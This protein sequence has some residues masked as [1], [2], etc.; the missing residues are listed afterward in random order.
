VDSSYITIPNTTGRESGTADFLIERKYGRELTDSIISSNETNL[1]YD[2]DLTG[3]P[4]VNVRVVIDE[5]TNDEIR[6]RGN[7]NLRIIAGTTEP[8]T[9]RGRFDI[10]DGIYKFSFQSFFKKPFELNKNANNYIEWNG[11]PNHPTV[12]IEGVYKTKEKVDFSPLL[13]TGTTGDNVTGYRDY[14][15][16]IAK[17]KGDLFKP[18]IKFDLDFPPE[19]PVKKDFYASQLIRVILENE[20][21]LNKHV[22]FLVVFNK[23]APTDVGSSLKTSGV[24][25]VVNSISG[26]LSGQINKWLNNFL[27]T[28]FKIEGLNINFS[29]SLYDPTPFG[30]G[31]SLTGYNSDINVAVAKT[32]LNN[33]IVLTFEGTADVPIQNSAQFKTDLLKNL[34]AEFLVNKS[35]TIRVNLFYKENIDLLS[36][37]STSSSKSRRFGTS[38]AYRREADRFWNLFFK[39]KPKPVVP[40]TTTTTTVEKKEGN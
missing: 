12:N 13:N 27:A 18:D 28:T 34:T 37:T 9:M 15:Y 6:G 25:L 17:L 22:A 31:G 19:S 1:T 20:N 29:G 36:G 5:L 2:I 35:G 21:E 39:K 16:V 4:R 40:T 10:N 14:V 26:F 8:M 11:D 33:R 32:F 24:D 30:A 38:L 7:G 3:N 23:F